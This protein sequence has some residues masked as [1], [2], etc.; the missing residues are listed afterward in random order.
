MLQKKKLQKAKAKSITQLGINGAFMLGM[1]L[2][3]GLLSV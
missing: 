2:L 1:L 3:V